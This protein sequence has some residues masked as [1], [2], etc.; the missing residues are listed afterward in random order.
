[1]ECF[2]KSR[3]SCP[4]SNHSITFRFIDENGDGTP[5]GHLSYRLID[6]SGS[7]HLGKLDAKGFGRVESL[8]SGPALLHISDL[9]DGPDVF[10]RDLR[11]RGSYPLPITELQVAAEGTLRRP[12][13]GPWQGPYI[14][15]AEKAEFHQV[16]V[17]DLVQYTKHLP[18][19]GKLSL[20]V[21]EGP[22][23][24]VRECVKN[25]PVGGIGLKPDTNYVFEVQAL[26]AWRPLLSL[27][28]EFSAL[29]LYQL[30]LFSTLSYGWFGQTPEK[31]GEGDTVSYPT[32]GSVGHV[33]QTRLA[34]RDEP[35]YF[36]DANKPWY[37]LVED[38]PYSKRLEV[39]PFDPALYPQNAPDLG[40]EQETPASVHFFNDLRKGPL[41]LKG[42]DTQAY[43]THDDRLVLIAV[44]GTAEGWD[45][46][47]DIDAAQVAMEDGNG[48]AHQ[49]FHDAFVALKPFVDNYLRQFRTDKKILVCGHSL[50]G[51]V[52]L[53]L[54]AWLRKHVTPEVILY[55]YGAPRS[56][57]A[58]FIESARGLVHHRIVNHSDPV[59][60]IPASWMDTDKRMWIS[61]LTASVAGLHPVGGVTLFLAGLVRLGGEPYQHHGEQRHFLPVPLAENLTSSVMW[62]P[63]C[64]G[65]EEAACAGRLLLNDMPER[66][67]FMGQLLSAHEHTLLQGYLPAC[68][69]TL[70][71]WQQA[72][73]K[74]GTVITPREDRW[75]R[76]EIE[77][78]R[79]NLDEWQARAH[80]EFPNGA[81]ELRPQD[82]PLRQRN[83]TYS[84]LKQRETEIRRAI[85]HAQKELARAEDALDR[86]GY[87]ATTPVTPLDVY[88]STATH[89]QLAQVVDRWLAH[90]ENRAEVRLA[91]IPSQSNS[92]A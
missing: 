52:A 90:K 35:A 22:A 92:F 4:L 30:A 80:R 5:Y 70:K 55:T 57:D 59:P 71:R 78:Y 24:L 11:S 13:G 38:T 44:R 27:D 73:L 25:V 15:A 43:A 36:A 3:L 66:R 41:D 56:G 32:L 33:L 63:G 86:L 77:T 85:N 82:R 87:L 39:V 26:R 42:T 69:A 72:S 49:G 16:E 50:G 68:W 61:G 48:Q 23:R 17:G 19:P 54:A 29:N 46:W 28:P 81:I 7:E 18:A 14:A 89:V 91:Q 20:R 9:Y 53:L 21:P 83:M 2:D 64:E 10:Y 74:G 84:A 47:L 88:G 62:Q 60:S 12:A 75:L 79:A 8:P 1:M 37:P 58:A 76:S 6:C 34:A 51:A 31:P 40:D 67:S 45:A 65:I